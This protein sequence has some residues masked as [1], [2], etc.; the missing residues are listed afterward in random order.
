MG[1]NKKIE[2]PEKNGWYWIRMKGYNIGTPC[3]FSKDIDDED[4]SYFLAGGMGDS[5]SAGIFIDDIETIGPEIIEPE[6]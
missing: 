3:W 4:D 6:F 5:S 1:K 2:L